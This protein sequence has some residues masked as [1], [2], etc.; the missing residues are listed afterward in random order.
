M[1]AVLLSAALFSGDCVRVKVRTAAVQYVAP[2]VVDQYAYANAIYA[3]RVEDPDLASL[4]RQNE[5][6]TQAL[7]AQLELRTG[8][9]QQLRGGTLPI[10]KQTAAPD[11]PAILTRNC[12][13]CHT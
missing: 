4:R 13:A 8:E 2:V 7:V 6:L 9:V 5:A 3:Y 1:I 12:A 11:V 10:E